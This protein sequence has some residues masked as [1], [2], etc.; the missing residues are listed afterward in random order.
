MRK[1]QISFWVHEVVCP[2]L[3]PSINK[4]GVVEDYGH[5]QKRGHDDFGFK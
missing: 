5:R 1:G 4:K 3:V 2:L